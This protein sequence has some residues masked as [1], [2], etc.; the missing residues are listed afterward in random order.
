MVHV[1]VQVA[2]Y[3][4][5]QFLLCSV[6]NG[7]ARGLAAVQGKD[8]IS[9]FPLRLDVVRW[10]SV[11]TGIRVEMICATSALPSA[12]RWVDVNMMAGETPPGT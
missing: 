2:I 12:S 6:G 5:H 9:Q 10:L 3:P 8:G 4:Q 11:A 1:W 7:T